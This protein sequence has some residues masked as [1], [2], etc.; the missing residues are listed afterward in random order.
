MPLGTMPCS[1]ASA[2]CGQAL[3]ELNEQ[4]AV[5]E[6]QADQEKKKEASAWSHVK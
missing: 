4:F 5:E 1:H 3:V 2:S 6:Q